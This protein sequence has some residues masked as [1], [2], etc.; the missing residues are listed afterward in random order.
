MPWSPIRG[1]SPKGLQSGEGFPPSGQPP[2]WTG[3]ASPE[4]GCPAYR[5]H[6]RRGRHV[7]LGLDGG[8]AVGLQKGQVTAAE[9]AFFHDATA[10]AAHAACRPAWK[11]HTGERAALEPRSQAP[12]SLPGEGVSSQTRAPQGRQGRREAPCPQDR[13][14]RTLHRPAGTASLMV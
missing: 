5:E 10:A 12:G 7:P 14:H 8:S 9:T 2:C 1:D 3:A 4:A 13:P 6:G 11:S